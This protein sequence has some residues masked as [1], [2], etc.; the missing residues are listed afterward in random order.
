MR[1]VR[2]LF[3]VLIAL[4]FVSCSSSGKSGAGSP[5]DGMGEGNIPLAKPGAELSDVNFA[6]DSAELSDGTKGIL[7]ENANWLLDNPGQDVVI[8]GHCDERGTNEY[9]MAL[10]Q[11]RANAVEAYIRSLGVSEAQL[12]TI[13]YGEELPLDPGS[14]EAAW[15][16][17]RRAHFA[18]RK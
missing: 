5:D 8:E 12:S 3:L 2:N 9:N 7:R 6:F 1:G 4:T 16:K 18:F 10:G 14:G 17:N 15:A 13:S 11:R